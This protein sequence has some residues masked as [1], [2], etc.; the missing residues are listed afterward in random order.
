MKAMA[1]APTHAAAQAD[2]AALPSIASPAVIFVRADAGEAG[3]AF[4]L[5]AIHGQGRIA[6]CLVCSS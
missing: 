2:H 1:T 4:M 5:A 6:A 3:M